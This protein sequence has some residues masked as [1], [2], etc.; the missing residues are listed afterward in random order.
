[1]QGINDA[2][3]RTRRLENSF[4]FTVQ[5][6][7][8]ILC[9][10]SSYLNEEDVFSASQVCQHWRSTL[11]SCPSLWTWISCR[12]GPRMTASLERSR[13]MPIHLM[14]QPPLSNLAV[15]GVLL[16]G[17]KIASL[18]A[19]HPPGEA[20][21]LQ[22][23]F[24]FSKQSMRRLHIYT[25]QTGWMVS[26]E[27]LMRD[28]WEDL[29]SL[30]E[31]CISG[32]SGPTDRLTAP[33]LSHLALEHTGPMQGVTVQTILGMLSGCPLLE[34]LL[35]MYPGH[36]PPGT[37]RIFV[38]LSHLRHIEVGGY[39]VDSGLITHLDFPPNVMAGF[40]SMYVDDICGAIPSVVRASM[41]HVLRNIDISCITLAANTSYPER[42]TS[43]LIRFEKLHGSLEI[44][45][46][47]VRDQMQSKDALFGEE[48]VL[49]SRSPRINNVTELHIVGCFFNNGLYLDR[50]SAAMPNVKSISFQCDL[51]YTFGPLT[52]K[53]PSTPAFPRLERV[54]VPVPGPVLED[55]V[56]RRKDQGIPLKTLVIGR[57][58]G[59]AYGRQEDYTALGELVDDLQVG[60]PTEIW[61]WEAGNQIYNIWSA[62]NVPGPVSR[63]GARWRRLASCLT[64]FRSSFLLHQDGC[65]NFIDLT[66]GGGLPDLPGAAC[67]KSRR[68]FARL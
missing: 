33:I 57:D 45:V 19:E 39:E 22:R 10:I 43:L 47:G 12:C 37:A 51:P 36:I 31:L 20:P 40:R 35:L 3:I 59:A 21:Q 67:N 24:T 1:M 46:Y 16:H 11:I 26:R 56:R 15:D 17:N 18:T 29:P 63:K 25:N 14:I 48:G 55:M 2:L 62:G 5:T 30:R 58:P 41:Q 27:L 8:E 65:S 4:H 7:Q 38:R 42:G 6:P 28:F 52:Y 61:N 9:A 66:L 64:T 54:M 34:T 49:F 50:M 13:S 44:T 32:H 53:N 60:C 23:L 68:V